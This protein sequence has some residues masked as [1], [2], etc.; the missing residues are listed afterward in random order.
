MIIPGT[1][2][3][4]IIKWLGKVESIE[5]K[6][7]TRLFTISSSISDSFHVDQSVAHDGVCL[8]IVHAGNGKHQVEAVNESLIKKQLYQ[9]G[10]LAQ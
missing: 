3:S 2:F 1:M 7:T 6:G 4:G 10:K 8:T 9:T 5:E